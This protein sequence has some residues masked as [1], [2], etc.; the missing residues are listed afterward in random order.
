MWVFL[1]MWNYFSYPK[2]IYNLPGIN[3]LHFFEMPLPA[4]T[5]YIPFSREVFALF[6]FITGLF[7]SERF[8]DYL[9]LNGEPK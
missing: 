9:Q 4:Y 7:R 3:I 5:V 8:K 6:N 1:E 2:W